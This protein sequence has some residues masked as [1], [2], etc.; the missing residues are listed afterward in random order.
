[1]LE[2]DFEIRYNKGSEMPAEFLTT[3]FQDTCAI[4]ILDKDWVSLQGK[5][6]QRKL[7]SEALDKKWSYSFPML[8]WYKNAKEFAKE[9][10]II[11]N[12]LWI[13]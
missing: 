5:D 10:T 9:A 2:F 3:S 4:S 12:I 13:K 6:T 7:I 11:N 1:M 8:I